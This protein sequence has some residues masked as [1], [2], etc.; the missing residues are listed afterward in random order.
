[1]IISQKE[2]PI[3][4][5]CSA[6]EMGRSSYYARNTSKNPIVDR[7]VKKVIESIALEFSGYGYRRI[8]KELHRR[9][10]TV[11]HKKVLRIMREDNLLVR[12]KKFRPI[13]TYSGHGLQVYPNLA[14]DL[15]V[16]GLN[17]LWVSDITYIRLLDEY[18]YLAV[19]VDLFS[20]KCVG[21]DL[22]KNIDARLTLNA[23]EMAVSD[24]KSIGFDMLQR[25]MLTG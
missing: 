24:R 2:I 6:F 9:G 4:K 8:T 19:I 1:M 21:W 11:N 18:V 5:S 16:N 14:K 23:L 20:R 17:Q 10:K 22:G 15:Q 3:S 12:K 7:E 25:T 13:T